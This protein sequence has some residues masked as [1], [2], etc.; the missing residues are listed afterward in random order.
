MPVTW[1]IDSTEVV[2]DKNWRQTITYTDGTNTTT[3]VYKRW[4]KWRHLDNCEELNTADHEEKAERFATWLEN[5]L[6]SN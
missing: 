6:W 3:R 5:E 4:K 1:T 2:D